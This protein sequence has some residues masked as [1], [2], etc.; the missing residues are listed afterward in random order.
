[1]DGYNGENKDG[2]LTDVERGERSEN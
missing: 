1:M 2:E